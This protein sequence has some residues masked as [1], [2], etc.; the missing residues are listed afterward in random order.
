MLV[1]AIDQLSQTLFAIV[2]MIMRLA[3]LGAFGAMAFTVGR[4]GIGIA[5]LA[6]QADGGR[7]PHVSL[8]SVRRARRDRRLD[9]TQLVRVPALHRRK[10]S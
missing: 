3:P 6:R 10:K 2:G 8:F 7:L 1:A 4:Y 9:R 5:A